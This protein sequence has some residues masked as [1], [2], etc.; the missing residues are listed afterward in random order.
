VIKF[1]IVLFFLAVQTSFAQPFSFK[2]DSL[3]S[4]KLSTSYFDLL[5]T[6]NSLSNTVLSLQ[7]TSAEFETSFRNDKLLF[8]LETGKNIIQIDNSIS[9]VQVR[10]GQSI[11]R[12]TVDNE[13]S[14][15]PFFTELFL[16]VNQVKSVS[17]FDYGG[18][19]GFRNASHWFE[20]FRIGYYM[21]S[22]PWILGLKY[23]DSE[24]D[25]NNLSKLSKI[26]YEI[27]F[28]PADKTT[29]TFEYEKYLSSK[30][31]NENPIFAVD[32]KTSG[33]LSK[34]TVANSS[35]AIP[36]EITFTHG[37][38]ESVCGL[39]YSQ[40]SFSQNLFYG[41]LYN[42]LKVTS[43][44]F[45]S[46][47]WFPSFSVGY[48]FLRGSMVGDI[49]SWPFTSVM[50]S[51][52]LNRLNYR[53]TGHLYLFSFEAEKQF[54]FSTFSIQPEISIHQIL[55]EVTFDT[56]QPSYLV[57]GVKDF[58][59][60]ILPIRKIIL[61]KISFTTSFHF[62]NIDFILEAGQ[63]VP[64]QIVKKEL[65]PSVVSPGIAVVQ[66]GPSRI[67]GGRWISFHVRVKF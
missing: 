26:F 56:W 10:S 29:L 25:I 48:H 22:F 3:T 16:R 54:T 4:V 63:F 17:T 62:Q 37:E 53:L 19:F 2:N 18:S 67:V 65:P 47:K 24:M 52:I 43:S 45:P 20:R 30:N 66:S 41:A 60:N 1:L 34:L 58:S 33:S 13:F 57:F 51:F 6:K 55:P 11:S 42:G 32:D 49:Q 61:G 8:S 44:E 35:C 28:H 36:V 31:K 50:T 12:L 59:R 27:G 14:F 5:R 46:S 15:A 38:G 21:Y 7:K 39:F 9:Q 40:N 23:Q 64:L